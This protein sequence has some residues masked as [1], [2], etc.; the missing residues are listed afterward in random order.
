MTKLNLRE[1]ALKL[2]KEGYSYRYIKDKV[3]VSLGTLSEWLFHVKFSPNQETLERIGKARVAAMLS[4]HKKKEE[5]IKRALSL[6]KKDIGSVTERDVFMLGL[7]I[8]IGEGSKTHNN[9]R[10]INADPRVIRFVIVWFKSKLQFKNENFR[11]RLHLYPDNNEE[12]C[13]SF[14]SKK[15]NIPRSLFLKSQI[16]L[17]EGKKSK[18]V[19][20]LPYGTAHLSIRS[21]GNEEHGV[22]L[23]R[24]IAGWID[25]VLT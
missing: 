13:L 3:G 8:Y 16:D 9:I 19:R 20:K 6:A 23:A 21:N 5:Q 10:V 24:R 18:K 1:Q 17:R 7:G 22:F 2:R 4:K 12:E 15:L 25:E 14:W 11:V